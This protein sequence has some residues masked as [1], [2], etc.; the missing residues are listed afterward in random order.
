MTHRN[1][2]HGLAALLAVALAGPALEAAAQDIPKGREI[3]IHMAGSRSN[4]E[5][6][7]P[8]RIQN[9]LPNSKGVCRGNE[10][11]TED[12]FEDVSW[13]LKGT[14]LPVGWKVEVRMKAGAAK[15]CFA[16]APFTL[17]DDS[18]VSSGPV[19]GQACDRWDVWPYDVVLFNAAGMEK[20]RV[21]PLV[22]I[23]H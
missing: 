3:H 17:R 12:C 1:V 15:A 23:N 2:A 19:D 5:G 8:Y 9:V 13:V 4:P 10:N 14:D 16:K 6:S 18:P 20:G 7:N 22:V 21:D 11:Q